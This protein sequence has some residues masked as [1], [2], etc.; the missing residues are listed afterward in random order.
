MP[1]L[2]RLVV[3]L[4]SDYAEN[5]YAALCALLSSRAAHGWE[6]EEGEDGLRL[7]LHFTLPEAGAECAAAL[8]AR[9]PGLDLESSQSAACDW[10]EAWK[11]FF[12]PVEAGEH[13]L[14][15]APWM[16]R[17]K[18]ETKRLPIII[19]PKTAFGTGHHASTALCLTALSLLFAEKVLR[20]GMRFLDLGTG[21]GI[22]AIGAAKLGLCGQALD[23]DPIAV[24]NA[25]ENR[26]LN[27]ISP[28]SLA[29]ETGD[30][31]LAAP[32]FSLVMANILA[33]PLMDM[34][35]AMAAL[36]GENSARPRL[37][38]SGILS[39]QA[40]AV[41]GCYEALGFAAPRRL[42]REEWSALIF[43]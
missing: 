16:E 11:E 21:S 41:A 6:E 35:P 4:P 8:L 17:E 1:D 25:L 30:L 33:G 2:T 19:E 40:D 18:S 7:I 34:A 20:P 26:L 3:T 14:V 31:S 15:L 38:L 36:P 23:T 9:F 10:L 39:R 43:T 42:E 32:P 12:T 13:F 24:D 28:V 5:D 27:D 22:L 29:V 37:I